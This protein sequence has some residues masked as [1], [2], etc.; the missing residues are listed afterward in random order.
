MGSQ[1]AG[2]EKSGGG[3]EAYGLEADL[4]VLRLPGYA[5]VDEGLDEL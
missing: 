2:R 1:R 4:G 3:E 5:V